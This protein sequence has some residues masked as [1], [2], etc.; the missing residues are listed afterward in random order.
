MGEGLP[1]ALRTRLL[2]SNAS[3]ATELPEGTR[4]SRLPWEGP[5]PSQ[6]RFAQLVDTG[7]SFEPTGPVYPRKEDQ[8]VMDREG[9]AF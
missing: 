2:G 6:A 7:Q 9:R 5:Q 4:A 3:L 8:L 1:R